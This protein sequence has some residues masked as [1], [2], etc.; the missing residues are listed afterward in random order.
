MMIIIKKKII[1]APAE[2]RSHQAQNNLPPLRVFADVNSH[3]D[4][5]VGTYSTP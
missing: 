4:K 5:F 3:T 2:Q 1:C